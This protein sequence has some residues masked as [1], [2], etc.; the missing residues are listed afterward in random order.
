VIVLAMADQNKVEEKFEG[1]VRFVLVD[2]QWVPVHEGLV[3]EPQEQIPDYLEVL[4]QKREQEK[5][6]DAMLAQGQLPPHLAIAEAKAEKKRLKAKQKNTG[7]LI[8]GFRKT[9]SPLDVEEFA[10]WI[11]KFAGV[12]KKNPETRRRIVKLKTNEDGSFS[13]DV[14]VVFF[15]PE[16]VQQALDIVEGMEYE[17]GFRLT[18]KRAKKEKKEGGGEKSTARKKDKRIKLYDQEKELDWEEE[19]EKL[20]VIVTGLFTLDEVRQG[21]VDFY[22][23]LKSDLEAELSKMGI[24]KGIKIFNYNPD[25]V[26]A[27]KFEK[28]KGAIRCVDIMNGR[29]FAG[30]QLKCFYYDG[31]TNYD[32]PESEEDRRARIAKF[33]DWLGNT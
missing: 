9:G 30:R 28:S 11:T 20:H 5:M 26:V 13:G 27:V 3:D 10:D 8:S 1:G 29:F 31:F 23:E 18:V 4:K 33:G 25:G 24:V 12:V 17:S 22:D 21:S 7:V 16:S 6:E 14:L 2:N 19:E 32:V 15:R